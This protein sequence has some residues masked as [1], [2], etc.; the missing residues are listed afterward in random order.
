M[1]HKNIRV[2]YTEPGQD[3]IS[4]ESHKSQMGKT[5]S[6]RGKDYHEKKV[7]LLSW[8]KLCK[9]HHTFMAGESG[10]FRK[11]A[12]EEP[13]RAVVSVGNGFNNCWL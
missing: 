1:K 12:C 10:Q 2:I 9:S 13:E 7:L 4:Q 6:P 5:P 3:S 11:E 8:A